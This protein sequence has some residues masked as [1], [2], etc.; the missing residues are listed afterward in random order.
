MS[1]N[2]NNNNNSLGYNTKVSQVERRR[3]DTEVYA[4][5]AAE[6]QQREEA[7]LLEGGDHDTTTRSTT[8]NHNDDEKP[9]FQPAPAHAAGPEGSQRAFLRARTAPVGHIDAK[10]GS[11]EM[12]AVAAA[13]AVTTTTSSSNESNAVKKTGVGWHCTVCD[14]FLKD[15]HTYLDHIN[16]RKHQRTL[17]FSMRVQRSTETDLLSKLQQLQQQNQKQ[18]KSDEPEINYQQ[19]VQDKDEQERLRKEERQRKRQERR[20]LSH[21]KDNPSSLELDEA[22]PPQPE[23]KE[24]NDANIEEGGMDPDLAAIMGFSGFGSTKG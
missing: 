3:W 13:A 18:Q 14:C 23:E 15:S 7:S 12:M 4:Q 5:K 11:M 2:N 19:L 9:E 10:V 1:N 16:G 8:K 20:K 22:P 6:R 21:K 24:D 17:G